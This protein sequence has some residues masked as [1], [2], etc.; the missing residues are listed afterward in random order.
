MKPSG[1]L[2]EAVSRFGVALKAKLSSKAVGGAPENRPRA[3]LEGLLRDVAGVLA[4]A[5]G[6]IIAVGESTLAT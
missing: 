1:P 3:P 4:F 2:S 6:E 5:A